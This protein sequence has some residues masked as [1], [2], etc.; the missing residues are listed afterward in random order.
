MCTLDSSKIFTAIP[1][2]KNDGKKDPSL[3]GKRTAFRE[4]ALRV[5]DRMKRMNRIPTDAVSL[6]I[7]SILFILSK[8][9]AG[10]L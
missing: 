8:E 6:R 1:S 5:Q 3:R 7:L 2:R 9:P 4:V 10:R